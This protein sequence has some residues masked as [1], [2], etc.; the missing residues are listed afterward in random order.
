[1]DKWSLWIMLKVVDRV[2]SQH[3]VYGK[4][5]WRQKDNKW[6]NKIELNKNKIDRNERRESDTTKTEWKV[7]VK[8][9][10]NVI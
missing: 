1:M 3:Q 6:N 7:S 8:V 10:R 4:Y 9:W 5:K 2:T